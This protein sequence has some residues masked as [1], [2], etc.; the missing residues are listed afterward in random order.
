MNVL[1]LTENSNSKTV[2][3]I[4]KSKFLPLLCNTI[5]SASDLIKHHNISAIVIDKNHRKVDSIEFIL[6]AQDLNSAAPI[7]LI[8]NGGNKAIENIEPLLFTVTEITEDELLDKLK[9]IRNEKNRI[10]N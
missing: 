3:I 8:N 1:I 9:N 4:N 2:R 10:V 6:N 5:L 7:F